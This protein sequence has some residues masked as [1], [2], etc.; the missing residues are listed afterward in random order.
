MI[1]WCGQH[2]IQCV[3]ADPQAQQDSHSE[4]HPL[5]PN[6]RANSR[7]INNNKAKKL[8]KN[9]EKLSSPYIKG[10]QLGLSA[11]T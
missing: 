5:H 3:G 7:H 1:V 8:L 9:L 4:I 6:N 10:G 2:R 11:P